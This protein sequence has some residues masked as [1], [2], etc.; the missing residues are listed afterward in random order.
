MESYALN[1]NYNQKVSCVELCWVMLSCVECLNWRQ[2]WPKTK[3][4]EIHKKSFQL[5]LTPIRPIINSKDEWLNSRQSSNRR[6]ND[7]GDRHYQHCLTFSNK[8]TIKWNIT[9]GHA[10]HR[11][12][13]YYFSFLLKLNQW[14]KYIEYIV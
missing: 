3:L 9:D 11:Q 14:H 2:I 13:I 4:H 1:Y 8:L 6:M 12:I 7:S 5:S 10:I